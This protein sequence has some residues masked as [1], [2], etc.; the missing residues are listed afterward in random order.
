LQMAIH[1]DP[2]D[3]GLF[4]ELLDQAVRLFG[5][6]D[7]EITA[8][9]L[10]GLLALCARHLRYFEGR[11]PVQVL[12]SLHATIQDLQAKREE[13]VLAGHCEGEVGA[14]EAWGSALTRTAGTEERRLD[15]GKGPFTF[16]EFLEYYG[17][18][19][20]AVAHWEDGV[21]ED[22]VLQQQLK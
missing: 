20:E 21:P 11:A 10:S 18:M 5:E 14:G 13:A 3:V 9:F 15:Q 6:G 22:T 19:P 7:A 8:P 2:T 17:D 1:V 4:V 16:Q 12:H